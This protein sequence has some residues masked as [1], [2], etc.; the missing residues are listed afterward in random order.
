MKAYRGSRGIA[1]L[2][3][4]LSIRWRPLVNFA[5]QPLYTWESILVPL[6]EEAGWPLEPLLTFWSAEKSLVSTQIR[7][8]D[9]PVNSTVAILTTP[10]QLTIWQ[11]NG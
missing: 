1:A 10:P 4:N 9:R 3:L 6:E 7:N 11:D 2:I 5:H 8:P